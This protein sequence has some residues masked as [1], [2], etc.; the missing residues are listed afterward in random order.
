MT[1]S[2]ILG[3][4]FGQS[5]ASIAVIGKE[6]HASCIANEEGE[7]QIAC[8]ISYNGEEIYIGNGAKPQLV[9]NA[10]N[11][12]VG[13]RNLLGQTSEPQEGARSAFGAPVEFG[14]SGPVYKVEVLVPPAPAA[15]PASRSAGPSGAATPAN[16]EPVLTQ[17]TVTVP[18]VTSL[19]LKTLYD[20]ATD[21]LGTAPTGVVISCPSFF[22]DNQKQ[23]LKQAAEQAGIPVVQILDETAAALVAYR[24]GLV[25]ERKERDLLGSPEEGDAGQMESRDKTVAVVDL[26]ETSLHVTIAQTGE[27]EYV[28]LAEKR[29]DKLGGRAFDDLLCSH[30][31]K[32]FTKKTKVALNLPS[33]PNAS[34]ADKRAEMKLRLA[35]EHTKRSLSASTGAATCAVES[36]KEGMDLSASINR[37]RFD[38]LASGVYRRIAENI[39]SALEQAQLDVAQVDEILLAGASTLL[40]GIANHLSM[41][42]APTVPVTSALDPSQVIAVG[43]ALQAYHLA[44]LPDDLPLD[45]V[46]SNVNSTTASKPIGIVFPDS[47]QEG[48]SS[49][50]SVVIPSGV[51]LPCRRKVQFAVAPGSSKVAVELWEASTT[52]DVTQIQPPAAS[53]AGDADESDDEQDDELEEVRTVSHTRETLLAAGEI[54]VDGR[55]D[56]VLEVVLKADASVHWKV[57]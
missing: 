29:D 28:K 32:E 53:D 46:L 23:A 16:R 22:N 50:H 35:V 1:S 3:I 9:K 14:S 2:T 25:E 54:V 11:T 43:C 5:F 38:G 44:Q 18:E 19:F 34:V 56:V 31:A 20:S 10:N 39:K 52:V 26:G 37:I 6:G 47:S 40:P 41:L 49:V 48:D 51:R 27:G 57:C 36:L 24:V 7:R 55:T 33:G 4:N 17:Q 13:F 12:I 15:T 21:F 45:K 8:A 30:F 42:V